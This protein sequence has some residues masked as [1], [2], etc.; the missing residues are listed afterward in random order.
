MRQPHTEEQ[1]WSNADGK[2]AYGCW[3]WKGGLHN[4]GYGRFTLNGK[5]YKAHRLAYELSFRKNVRD[6]CVCHKC[7]VRACINPH[8]MFLGTRADNLKDMWSKGRGVFTPQLGIKHGMA[9]L[10]EKDVLEIREK[11]AHGAKQV[12][13]AMEYSISQSQISLI[14]LRKKWKHLS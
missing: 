13:L 6:A 1:F 4:D 8:H 5:R 11:L 12:H 3:L 2:A 10:S 9:K 7:D 14:S